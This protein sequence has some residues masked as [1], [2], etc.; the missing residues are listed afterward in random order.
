MNDNL[1]KVATDAINALAEAEARIASLTAENEQLKKSASE[2]PKPAEDLVKSA[3]SDLAELGFVKQDEMEKTAQLLESDPNA[4][5][6]CIR[7]L[8]RRKAAS[9]NPDNLNVGTVVS[10]NAVSD[11]EHDEALD[12]LARGLHSY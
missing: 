7:A 3:A 11:S 1:N 10:S 6:R 9:V 8:V 12:A 2:A 4:A 5:I